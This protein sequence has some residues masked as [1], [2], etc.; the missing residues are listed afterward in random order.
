MN[1][2]VHAAGVIGGFVLESLPQHERSLNALNAGIR[3][4]AI[5]GSRRSQS[6]PSMPKT[7]SRAGMKENYSKKSKV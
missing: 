4:A 5:S 1:E 7:R 3:P 6:V 2:D